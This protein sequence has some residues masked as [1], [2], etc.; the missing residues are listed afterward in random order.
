MSRN[1]GEQQQALVRAVEK[2]FLL[3]DIP[4]LGELRLAARAFDRLGVFGKPLKFADLFAYLLGVAGQRDG[5]QHTLQAFA[6]GI[7][8]LLEFLQIGEVGRCGAQQLLGAFE[9]ILQP[10]GAIFERPPHGVGA[11]GEAPL[12]QRHQ[13]SDGPGARVVALRRGAGALAFHKA[14]DFVI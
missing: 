10:P 5:F 9:A 8:E 1:S 13:E 14:G 3:Q 11:G 2:P 6:L 4:K 7:L 12:V